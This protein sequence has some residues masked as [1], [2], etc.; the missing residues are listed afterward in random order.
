MVP[1][2]RS[3]NLSVASSQQKKEYVRQSAQSF[4][5]ELFIRNIGSPYALE[6]L[7]SSLDYYPPTNLL[8][9]LQCLHSV[10]SIIILVQE[11]FVII[12]GIVPSSLHSIAT[13]EIY[14]KVQLTH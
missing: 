11:S 3:P 12:P 13:Q 7:G 1:L 9:S 8:R 2:V 5:I 14:A 10:W 6:W 4:G